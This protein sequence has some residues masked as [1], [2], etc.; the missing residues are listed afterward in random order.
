MLKESINIYFILKVISL[1]PMG[2]K[3]IREKL[4]SISKGELYL[5]RSSVVDYIKVCQTSKYII[6]SRIDTGRGKKTI[7]QI[8]PK[9]ISF[10]KEMDK[11]LETFLEIYSD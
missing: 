7:Y 10:L 5:G 6:N 1:E 4:D 8:Q 3:S 2:T 9:G 11:T